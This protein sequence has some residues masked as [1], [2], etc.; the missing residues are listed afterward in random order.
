M[1]VAKCLTGGALVRV[2]QGQWVYAVLP[3][4][5]KVGSNVPRDRQGNPRDAV[6]VQGMKAAKV[7]S[8]R[9]EDLTPGSLVWL[10]DPGS[11]GQTL[12][13]ML[14]VWCHVIKEPPPRAPRTAVST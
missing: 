2:R 1:A 5:A 6:D 9:A 14:T 7:V 13:G 11:A 4:G 10:A 8:L 3:K 12:P